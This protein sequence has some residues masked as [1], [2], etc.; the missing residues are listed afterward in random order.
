MRLRCSAKIGRVGELGSVTLPMVGPD[1]FHLVTRLALA[2][3]F[4]VAGWLPR[5]GFHVVGESG[6]DTV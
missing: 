1:V 6:E 5:L 2:H 3:V 4:E